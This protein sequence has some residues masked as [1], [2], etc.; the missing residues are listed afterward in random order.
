[1]TFTLS[2]EFRFEAAHFLPH[3]PTGHPCRK[4]HGHSYRLWIAVRG[5]AAPE[6]GWVM[7]Y[8]DLSRAVRPALEPLDHSLLNAIPGLENPT[9]ERLAAWCWE[10]LA[11]ALPNLF[12]VTVQET[13]QSRC[14]Y[15]GPG[16]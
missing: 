5:E 14:E 12:R 16:R 11:P 9:A 1:M 7:D 13:R 2:K 8:G 15:E 10:R 6:T 4:M 3:V